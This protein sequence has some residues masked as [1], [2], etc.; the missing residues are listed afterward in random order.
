[1]WMMRPAGRSA[2]FMAHGSFDDEGYLSLLLDSWGDWLDG[3][4]A[5]DVTATLPADGLGFDD[6]ISGDDL[7]PLADSAVFTDTLSG[8]LAISGSLSDTLGFSTAISYGWVADQSDEL[9]FNDV[10]GGT[11][12]IAAPLTST[13]TFSEVLSGELTAILTSGVGLDDVLG[14]RL[15]LVGVLTSGIGLNDTLLLIQQAGGGAGVWVINADTGAVSRYT[16]TPVVDSGAECNGTLYLATD[17]GLYAL[18]S[19]TDDGA[20]IEWAARGGM[21]HFGTDLLKR[22]RDVN[23]LGKTAGVVQVEVVSD[24]YGAKQEAHYQAPALTRTNPR[25][26]VVK[27]GQGYQSVYWTLGL[28]GTG[29]AEIDEV[30]V[31]PVP[32]SRRR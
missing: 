24:R 28:R 31:N 4:L 6:A 10:I 14:G 8:V 30:R 3:V 26:G 18:D 5:G 32:L 15:S 23:V 11:V 21:T 2:P 13:M 1:M 9:G 20:A 17:T 29:A 27:V 19:A 25:D 7:T 12:T 22:V 16:M